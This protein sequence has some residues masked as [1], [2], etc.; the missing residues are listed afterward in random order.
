MNEGLFNDDRDFIVDTARACIVY[1][2]VP[3]LGILFLPFGVACGLYAYRNSA[4]RKALA[5]NSI[6][7][8]LILIV[9]LVLW[10]LLYYVPSLA[11]NV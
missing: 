10:W 6:A 8:V 9:Q 1:S 4:D 11:N 3:Y 7:A 5:M 2:L